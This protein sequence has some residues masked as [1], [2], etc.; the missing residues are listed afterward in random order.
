MLTIESE[1]HCL[2]IAREGDND[3]PWDVQIVSVPKDR[4]RELIAKAQGVLAS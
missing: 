4:L 3:D 2:V 1:D